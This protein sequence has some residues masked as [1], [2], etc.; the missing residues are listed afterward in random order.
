MKAP[1][2]PTVPEEGEDDEDSSEDGGVG[3]S[4]AGTSVASGRTESSNAEEESAI[5]DLLERG[6]D[7]DDDEIEEATKRLLA[8]TLL[9]RGHC[10]YLGRGRRISRRT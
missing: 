7:V 5:E 6:S 8:S 4:A 9:T 3:D 10:C 1:S 2:E